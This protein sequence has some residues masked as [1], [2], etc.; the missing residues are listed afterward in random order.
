MVSTIGKVNDM[1]DGITVLNE[2][3][4]YGD[5]FDVVGFIITAMLVCGSFIIGNFISGHDIFMDCLAG[6][7]VGGVTGI[8][9]GGLVGGLAGLGASSEID[10]VK[11]Q[12]TI[13]ESVSFT[14]FDKHY[15]ILDR[16]GQIY[17]IKEREE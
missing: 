1:L 13:D 15:M 5:A 11:Y 12:V 3:A 6:L 2:T 10:Y 17:T 14:E 9:L 7:I 4:V 8:M 16:D